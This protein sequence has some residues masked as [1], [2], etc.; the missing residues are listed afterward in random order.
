MLK[1]LHALHVESDRILQA[2]EQASAQR[3]TQGNSV[4]FG[5]PKQGVTVVKSVR[6]VS[7]SRRAEHVNFVGLEHSH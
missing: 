5:G 4:F 7:F 2:K 3:V 1:I 6:M